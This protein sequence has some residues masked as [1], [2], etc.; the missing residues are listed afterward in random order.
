MT[1]RLRRTQHLAALVASPRPACGRATAD[2]VEDL[3]GHGVPD[4]RHGA[5]RLS[6][7]PGLAVELDHEAIE[8]YATGPWEGAAA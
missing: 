2:L 4:V 5:L 3:L 1:I 8:R 7:A 6:E